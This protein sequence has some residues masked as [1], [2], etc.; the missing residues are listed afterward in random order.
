MATQV[1]TF[2]TNTTTKIMSIHKKRDLLNWQGTIWVYGTFGGGTLALY[3]SP[4][5]GT[6]KIAMPDLSGVA[7]TATANSIFQSVMCANNTNSPI[8][9]YATLTG[10]TNPNLTVRI[11]DNSN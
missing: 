5:N 10:A 2:T 6:T 3:A 4:D 9:L 11:D 1:T 8:T 7:V